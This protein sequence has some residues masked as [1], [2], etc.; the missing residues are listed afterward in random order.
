MTKVL[1][2]EEGW[3]FQ[4]NCKQGILRYAKLKWWKFCL[5]LAEIAK[6]ILRMLTDSASLSVERKLW[7]SRMHLSSYYYYNYAGNMGLW[8]LRI[9]IAY[10]SHMTGNTVLISRIRTTFMPFNNIDQT[11]GYWARGQY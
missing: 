4:G 5:L 9:Q 7:M 2:S 6:S 1:R 10:P 3:A 8:D 11:T